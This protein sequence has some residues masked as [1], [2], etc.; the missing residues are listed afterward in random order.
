MCKVVDVIRHPDSDA[1]LAAEAGVYV[2]LQRK[3]I[4]RLYGYYNV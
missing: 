4:P 2:T 3:N 1:A